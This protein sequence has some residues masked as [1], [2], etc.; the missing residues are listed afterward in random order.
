MTPAQERAL[1][2]NMVKVLEKAAATDAIQFFDVHGNLKV[3]AKGFRHIIDGLKAWFF[4]KIEVGGFSQST[5]PGSGGYY[6]WGEDKFFFPDGYGVKGVAEESAIVHE[7]V[8]ALQDKRERTYTYPE[9]ELA[10]FTAEALYYRYRAKQT[11][12]KETAFGKRAGKDEKL[13]RLLKAAE[14]VAIVFEDQTPGSRQLTTDV[15]EV[16]D[17]LAAIKAFPLYQDQ[18]RKGKKEKRDG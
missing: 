7:A 1:R 9:H 12:A 14:A 2:D 18:E 5:R 16:A 10:S 8:H 4:G 3:D 17:L 11:K 13:A 15:K 6:S